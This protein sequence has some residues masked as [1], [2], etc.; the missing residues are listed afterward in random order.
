[1]DSAKPVRSEAQHPHGTFKTLEMKL[2]SV[3]LI[4]FT[5][6]PQTSVVYVEHYVGLGTDMQSVYADAN[7]RVIGTDF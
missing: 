5:L 7:A 6:P 1:M 4:L 3:T 2:C